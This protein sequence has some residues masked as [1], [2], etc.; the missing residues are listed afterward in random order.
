V[1]PGET[2]ETIAKE[3]NVPWQL[4]AKINGI[5]AVD[6]VRPGQELKVVRGPFSATVDLTRKQMTLF[7]DG[8]YAGRFP[9][10]EANVPQIGEGEWIVT[11]CTDAPRA[12]LLSRPVETAAN[13]AMRG[14]LLGSAT[15]AESE[16]LGVGMVNFSKADSTEVTEILS[17]GS[18]VVIRR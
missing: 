10:T 2:L 6:Q 13:M 14:V 18:R 5:S 7:V 11:S 1:K 15:P 3:Y 16:Q 8:R 9:V 12:M 17:V 4:L